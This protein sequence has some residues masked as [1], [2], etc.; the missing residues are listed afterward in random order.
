MKN[1][2]IR[3]IYDILTG[4]NTNETDKMACI[5]EIED[6]F[7]KN[8]E[9]VTKKMDFY[10]ELWECVAQVLSDKPMTVAEIW[11]E[12]KDNAPEEATR[13]KVSY[14][15]THYWTEKVVKIEGKPNQYRIKY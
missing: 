12:I 1:T 5:R 7:T 4:A 8:A 14:A 3:T 10:D 9:K 15:L 6:M 13:N 11:E 2:T